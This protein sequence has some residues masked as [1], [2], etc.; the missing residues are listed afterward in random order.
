MVY[1]YGNTESN[2][3]LIQMVDDHDLKVIESQVNQINRQTDKDF[4][5]IAIKV[6]NWNNDLSP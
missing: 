6:Q 1:T 2:N 4:S 5:L 3:V